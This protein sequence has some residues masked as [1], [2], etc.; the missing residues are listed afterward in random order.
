MP[1]ITGRASA[2]FAMP[3]NPAATFPIEC[4]SEVGGVLIILL[5]PAVVD[6]TLEDIDE[7]EDEVEG[8]MRLEDDM[9]LE[10]TAAIGPLLFIYNRESDLLVAITFERGAVADN[11]L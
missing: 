3:M 2:T 9:R 1:L 11:P 8:D 5:H 7:Y 6:A 4:D 10:G